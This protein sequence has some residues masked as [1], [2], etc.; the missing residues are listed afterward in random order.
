MFQEVVNEKLKLYNEK[1]VAMNIVMFQ[2][3]I[4]YMTRIYRII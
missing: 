4:N 1:K 2:D 3:A